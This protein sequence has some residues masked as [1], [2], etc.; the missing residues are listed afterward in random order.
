MTTAVKITNLEKAASYLAGFLGDAEAGF[1][2]AHTLH[3]LGLITP[4]G[5]Q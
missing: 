2:A 5:N 4:E 3:D 1:R